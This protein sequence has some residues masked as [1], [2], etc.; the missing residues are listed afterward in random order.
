MT[1]F[2]RDRKLMEKLNPAWHK[3]HEKKQ[4]ISKAY[5]IAS[6]MQSLYRIG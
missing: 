5:R 2:Q 1:W 4:K 3:Q 6:K